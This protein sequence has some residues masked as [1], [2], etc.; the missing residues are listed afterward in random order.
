MQIIKRKVLYLFLLALS[1]NLTFAQPGKIDPTFNPTDTG[2][3]KGDGG[4]VKPDVFAQSNGK[5]IIYGTSLA[6]YDGATVNQI[7]RLNADGSLDP[8]FSVGTAI[9]RTAEP[10]AFYSLITQQQDGKYLVV[11]AFNSFNGV[12][13]KS[14]V[15]L[16]SDG[17]VDESFDA[18][19]G[20]PGN[21]DVYSVIALNN[22]SILIAGDFTSYN[23][24]GVKSIA[25]LTSSG[26]LDGTFSSQCDGAIYAMVVQN[27]GKIIIGGSFTQY[28]TVS[29]N[30]VARLDS[31]GILDLTFDAGTGADGG[32]VD[33]LAIQQDGKVLAGGSFSSFN[34]VSK[35]NI[36]RLTTTGAVDNTFNPQ[37]VPFT[38]GEILYGISQQADGDIL[39]SG[40]NIQYQVNG[41]AVRK[42]I[43][44]LN[45]DGSLDNSFDIV[46]KSNSSN[47]P[48]VSSTTLSNGK[49]IVSGNFDLVNNEARNG[50]ARLN[51]DGTLDA[52]FS[53]GEG[54]GAT[55]G[56]VT[57]TLVLENKQILIGGNFSKFNNSRRNGIALLKPNGELDDAF[58]PGLGADGTVRTITKLGSG[59]VLIGGDFT[60]YNGTDVGHI[61]RLNADGS[62]DNSFNVSG[63]G[64]NGNILKIAIQADNKIII[65]GSFTKYN[66]L[67]KNFITRLNEDGTP[68]PS[69]T[70]TGTNGGVF[71]VLLQT[72]GDIIIGGNFTTYNGVS[73]INLA[74]LH[75][76]DGSLDNSFVT[77]VGP[78]ALVTTLAS[79]PDGKIIVY[80]GFTLYNGIAVKNMVRINPDNGSMDAGF[81]V[82][83]GPSPA[84][85]QCITVSNGKIFIG[86]N[87]TSFNGVNSN[88]LVSLDMATGNVDNT[89]SVGTGSDKTVNDLGIQDGD[90]IAVGNFNSY[91]NMG[92][93][94]VARIEGCQKPVRPVITSDFSNPLVP[95]L[96]SSGNSGNEWIING[97][98]IATVNTSALNVQEAGIYIVRVSTNGCY[99]YPSYPISICGKSSKPTITSDFSNPE[100]P[101]LTSSSTADNY[102]FLNGSLVSGETS[103]TLSVHEEGIYTVRVSPNSCISSD[104]SNPIS[105]CAKPGRP[106][107]T[108]DFTNPEVPVLTSSSS[109]DNYWFLNGSPVNGATSNTFSVHSPGIYTVRVS[110]ATCISSNFSDPFSVAITGIEKAIAE[111]NS[112]VF[113]NPASEKITFKL[114][115]TQNQETITISIL[116]SQGGLIG[117]FAETPTNGNITLDIGQLNAGLYIIKTIEFGGGRVMKFIKN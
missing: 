3:G 58:N 8:T 92:R 27:D 22:G 40:N 36:V 25:R 52:S 104:F 63:A 19:Q 100:A 81:S 84:N 26:S 87:F 85:V 34:G 101:V 31:E 42:G 114:E 103:T 90:L 78:S 46:C 24:V 43:F 97:N 56:N 75:G 89:F 66:G 112:G 17:S 80:G 74:R 57:C 70:G 50:V 39:V 72:N 35:G 38:N 94:R 71:S 29:R 30:S 67:T 62:L 95:I 61:A 96:T 77:G 9:N 23:G 13:R 65:A 48:R 41:T 83:T 111:A 69:F 18:G 15:R 79:Q 2:F 6:N 7:A 106:T 5:V 98:L 14:I 108:S 53:H 73:K 47:F 16:N 28:N 116:D 60:K 68:D 54:S 44:R 102:W 45:T 110:P 115:G 105:I 49:I 109:A 10:N 21:A 91:G 64:T 1:T 86:G 55:G 99:S 59:K 33:G 51:A 113:P 20:I 12:A 88:R 76:N 4:N 37:G 32:E 82:G 107:I 117:N 11:G 93:N